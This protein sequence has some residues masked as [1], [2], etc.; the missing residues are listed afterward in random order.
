MSK[1]L[2]LMPG[3][4]VVSE[5]E[6]DAEAT[7]DR[8]EVL[9]VAPGSAL[10]VGDVVILV[11]SASFADGS[12]LVRESD[13]LAIDRTRSK[14]TPCADTTLQR[15][16][17]VKLA[18]S[19]EAGVVIGVTQSERYGTR[20]TVAHSDGSRLSWKPSDLE[21]VAEEAQPDVA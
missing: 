13:V 21:L 18:P 5:P 17:R 10:C 12:Y 20:V 4:L 8:A 16:D 7:Y 3:V 9:E 6:E 15:G 2:E 19:Y 11:A 1:N 14:R